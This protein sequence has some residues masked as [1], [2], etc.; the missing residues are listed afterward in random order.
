MRNRLAN[1]HNPYQGKF[2]RVLV[3]CSAGLLRSPTAAWVLSNEPYNCNTRAAGADS[4][5]ALVPV[6]VVL[7]A[8]ADHIV[9]VNKATLSRLR[10]DFTDFDDVAAEAKKKVWCLDIPDSF[11]YRDPELVKLIHEGIEKCGLKD[12]LCNPQPTTAG[13]A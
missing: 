4:N 3:V 10:Y 6:D 9:T 5:F 13:A 8:W 1:C 2:P 12:A 11:N 7:L